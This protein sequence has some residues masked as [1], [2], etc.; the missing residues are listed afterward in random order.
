MAAAGAGAADLG[1][2]FE[3]MA[4][5]GQYQHEKQLEADQARQGTL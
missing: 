3:Y 4:F 1:G 5:V 2:R